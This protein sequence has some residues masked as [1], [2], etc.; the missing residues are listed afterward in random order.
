MP[1]STLCVSDQGSTVS[2]TDARFGGSTDWQMS[3][4]TASDPTP[5]WFSV[6]ETEAC[7]VNYFGHY[8]V[9]S[10]TTSSSWLI[11][12]DSGGHSIADGCS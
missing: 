4:S 5:T 12:D 6:T 11:H 8:S 10:V 7:L 9:G 1:G 3:S 2:D